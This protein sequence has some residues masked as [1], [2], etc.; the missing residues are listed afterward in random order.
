M[1]YMCVCIKVTSIYTIHFSY[2][3][4]DTQITVYCFVNAVDVFMLNVLGQFCK[5][6]RCIHAKC[7]RAAGF[8]FNVFESRRRLI[9]YH[10]N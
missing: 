5:C 7:A 3:I 10:S 4:M 1:Q 2:V 9:V 8:F 6:S